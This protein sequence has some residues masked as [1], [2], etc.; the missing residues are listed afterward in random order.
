[1]NDEQNLPGIF[2]QF[3][4]DENQMTFED[5]MKTVDNNDK[6]IIN[7]KGGQET[8]IAARLDLLPP[9][10]LLEVGK[11]LKRGAENYGEDNW[12]NLS[13][14]TNLN[15]ALVHANKYMALKR[16]GGD[17][18]DLIREAAQMSCRVLFFLDLL[19]HEQ[20]SCQSNA[21]QYDHEQLHQRS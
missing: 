13:V 6:K 20:I 2:T 15:H 10:A 18:A 8:D 7:T 17:T 21:V 9:L 4:G 12:R 11:I 3:N 16:A 19:I 1:M 14:E 5:Y